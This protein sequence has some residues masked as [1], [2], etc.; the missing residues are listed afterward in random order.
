MRWTRRPRLRRRA[1][2]EL[3]AKPV[4]ALMV[5][6]DGVSIASHRYMNLTTDHLSGLAAP[7]TVRWPTS[8]SDRPPG[9]GHVDA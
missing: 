3:A 1:Q 8:R 2:A 5:R 7:G 4:T 6:L 9:D